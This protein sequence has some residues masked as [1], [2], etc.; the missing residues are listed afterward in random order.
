MK[1]KCYFDNQPTG[2]IPHLVLIPLD[3][4]KACN[5]HTLKYVKTKFFPVLLLILFSSLHTGFGQDRFESVTRIL[6]SKQR[7]FGGNVCVLLSQNDSIIYSHNWGRYTDTTVIPIA[8]CS[9]WLTAALV[10]TFVD[11]HSLALDDS[12]GK[13]LPVF[14]KYGKGNI[15]I[16]EC[17][18]HTSG[19]NSGRI[20]L[21]S[22][23]REAHEPSLEDEVNKFVKLPVAGPPGSVFIYGHVGL[24]I[25]GRILEIITRKN[26][27]TLFQERIA[28]PLGMMHTTFVSKHAINPSGGAKST[29]SDYMKFLTMILDDGTYHGKRILSHHAVQEMETC[30]TS[31]V[32]FIYMPDQAEGLNYG[33]GEWIYGLDKNGMATAVSS[34]GLF[35][36]FPYI[37]LKRQY[38]LIIF[39]KTWQN[40][41]R[42]KNYDD[43][44]AAVNHVLNSEP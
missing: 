17:M 13:Y 9:K 23:I 32:K 31:H 22:I 7:A 40:R 5:F 11:D 2:I 18:S 39:M 29:A 36:S 42:K 20:N 16:G 25:V 33:L 15:T 26:F 12:I 41:G 34:P 21:F 19:L 38:A 28:R 43:I 24:N 10:M 35:G 6:N 44:L 3:I 30:R 1:A 14:T 27:E 4:R 8:S 37:D